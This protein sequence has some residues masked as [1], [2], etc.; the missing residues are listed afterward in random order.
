MKNSNRGIIDFLNNRFPLTHVALAIGC[1]TAPLS[2]Q[3]ECR[4]AQ[5]HQ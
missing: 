2:A 1:L 5:P 4:S 3:A